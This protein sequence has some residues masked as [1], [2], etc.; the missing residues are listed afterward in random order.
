[1]TGAEAV[2][3]HQRLLRVSRG[4][5]SENSLR[6]RI[7]KLHQLLQRQTFQVL[8]GVNPKLHRLL[9]TSTGKRQAADGNLPLQGLYPES[10]FCSL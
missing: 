5:V 2:Y 4:I 8:A 7:A 9:R 10:V 3:H 6:C 1:M